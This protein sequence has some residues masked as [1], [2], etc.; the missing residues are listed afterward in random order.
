[1]DDATRLLRGRSQAEISE[2]GAS[3]DGRPALFNHRHPDRTRHASRQPDRDRPSLT[4]S[5]T[6]LRRGLPESVRSLVQRKMDA[7]DAQDRQLLGAA[8]IQGVDFDTAVLSSALSLSNDQL[9]ERLERIEPE[10]ALVRFVDEWEYPDRSLT[11]RY[12]FSHHVYHNAFHESLRMTRRVALSQAI[13][14]ALAER[15]GD[16]AKE[17][18]PELAL[19]FESG[20][21]GVRAAEFFNL[22]ALASGRVHAHDEMRRLAE[23]GLAALECESPTKGAT[24][25]YRASELDLRM[26]LGLAI[27][28]SRGYAAPEVGLAYGRA[29]EL[30]R[31]IDDP[32]RVVPILIGL[33]AHYVVGG[34]IESSRDIGVEM[35]AL[36]DRLGNPHL[37]MIGEWLFGAALFHLGHLAD[38]HRHITRGL[39]L[40][41]P[42]FHGPRVWET[43]IEPGIFCRCEVARTQ[44]LQGA[45]DLAVA[46]V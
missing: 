18:A 14:N 32:G 37:Q 8:S 7:L 24:V 16:R 11:L 38:S 41:D 28:T 4:A 3:G 31:E 1:M 12:R 20:R 33:A 36:C 27:K 45:P 26:T 17:K 46:N 21:L 9:E 10:H 39:E 23:R 22:A 42:S 43:A 5:L 13:A 15:F 35:L 29:R 30:C 40:Y 44:C 19:L 6:E 34:E 2:R 25:A